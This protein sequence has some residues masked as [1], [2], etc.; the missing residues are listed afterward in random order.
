MIENGIA[1]EAAGTKHCAFGR[2]TGVR[3]CQGSRCMA[4]RWV[5]EAGST[6][7]TKDQ[8]DD[9]ERNL[10][11]G[12]YAHTRTGDTITWPARGVCGRVK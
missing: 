5:Q 6:T 3:I 4:W 7:V 10:I 8:A 2:D 12:G 9:I 11:K 1:D